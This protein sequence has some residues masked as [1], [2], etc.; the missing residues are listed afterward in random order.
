MDHWTKFSQSFS[1]VTLAMPVPGG[2]L[3]RHVEMDD[4]GE[5]VAVSICFVPVPPAATSQLSLSA[6]DLAPA[7]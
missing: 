7:I 6:V 4:D 3:V 5:A 1:H 2:A